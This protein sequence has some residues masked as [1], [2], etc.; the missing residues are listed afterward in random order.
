MEN[1][2]VG[3][4]PTLYESSVGKREQ[5]L[6]NLDRRR[7]AL[8]LVR[9]VQARKPEPRVFVLA[10]RPCVAYATGIVLARLDEKQPVARPADTVADAE[11]RDALRLD[12]RLERNQQT[13]A[14]HRKALRSPVALHGRNLQIHRIERKR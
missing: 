1:G 3:F 13:F 11:R 8:L 9:I 14:V 12:R 10:L 2:P 4:V 6:G 5:P 7:G